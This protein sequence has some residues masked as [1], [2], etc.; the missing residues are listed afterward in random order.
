MKIV[1]LASD[2]HWELFKNI[3]I[4]HFVRAIT[5][6]EL[7]V[8]KDAD[9]YFNLLENSFE[10]KYEATEKPIFIN[11]VCHTLQELQMPKNVIRINGWNGF[12][13]KNIWEIAGQISAETISILTALEKKYIELT[14]ELGF[15]S[16]RVIAM[17][18]NE[19][20][21]AKEDN[22]STAEEIDIAMK[23]GTNYPFG[24]FE[25]CE[26]IGIEN[27]YKLLQKLSLIDER[28]TPSDL[29]KTEMKNIV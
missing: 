15:V 24:P 20:Y 12:L 2:N 14:D 21:F 28:Y 16:A 4:I 1:V 18:I 26:K 13:E 22:V 27:V 7:F 25:W 23:L 6:D 8:Q 3:G 17:V 29:L 19:A 11:C 9:A 5:I 10:D